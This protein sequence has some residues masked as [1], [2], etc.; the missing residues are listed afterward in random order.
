VNKCQTLD[1]EPIRAT[2]D[3]SS[4]DSLIANVIRYTP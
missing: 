4:K 2:T 3:D 1:F